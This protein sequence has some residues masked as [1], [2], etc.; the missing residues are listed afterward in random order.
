MMIEWDVVKN[1]RNLV[2]HGLDFAD[3]EKVFGGSCVTFLDNRFDY[4][5]ERFV[6]LGG[7]WRGAL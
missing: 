2:K 6:S 5:E 1:R 7:Y 3:A 4:G